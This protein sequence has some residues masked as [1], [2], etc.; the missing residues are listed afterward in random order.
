MSSRD[1][2]VEIQILGTKEADVSVRIG[3]VHHG[4][5]FFLIKFQE[6]K[7]KSPKLLGR[8]CKDVLETGQ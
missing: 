1:T 6:K 8:F 7:K 5:F 3:L 2:F 4:F